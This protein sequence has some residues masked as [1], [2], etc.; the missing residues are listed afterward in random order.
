MT[1]SR[2]QARPWDDAKRW[3]PSGRVSLWR[4]TENTRN[5]PGWHLR[6]DAA[7]GDSLLTLIDTLVGDPSFVHDVKITAPTKADLR[8]P[9]NGDGQAAWIA[10]A[11]LR[12]VL[13]PLPGEWSFPASADPAVLTLGM[14][15]LAPLREGIAGMRVG[16]GDYAIGTRRSGEQLWFWW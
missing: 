5:Y 15:W 4:Y 6:A 16:R 14:D 7:G 10:P 3:R 13:S 8:V 12:I 1:D 11:G 2:Q 9:N